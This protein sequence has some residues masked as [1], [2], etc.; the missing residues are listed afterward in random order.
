MKQNSAIPPT[1]PIA[2]R[3]SVDETTEERPGGYCTRRTFLRGMGLVTASLAWR[4]ELPADGPPITTQARRI[5]DD[6]HVFITSAPH[7][8]YLARVVTA[9]E[10]LGKTFATTGEILASTGAFVCFNGS[11]FEGDGSPSGLFVSNGSYKSPVTYDKGDGILYIDRTRR[12][13]IISKYHYAEHKDNI[14]DALQI[15]L[16]T[17]DDLKL[18]EDKTYKR[19]LPR[20]FIGTTPEGI[21]DIIY[22]N[23]NFTFGDRYMKEIHGCTVVGALDGGSSASAV[24][25]LGKSSYNESRGDRPEA[26][27]ANFIVLYER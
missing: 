19:R 2:G 9:R 8:R 13:R 22:K 3:R 12:I 10:V 20:N 25:K 24:D 1:G 7:G 21:V 18:Y 4:R 16:L 26:A 23:T 15:N 11:F 5:D 27:V 14:I 17:E 6:N